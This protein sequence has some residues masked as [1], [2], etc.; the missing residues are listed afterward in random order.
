MPPAAMKIVSRSSKKKML[1]QLCKGW[2]SVPHRGMLREQGGGEEAGVC[3]PE[4]E[5]AVVG[6][7]GEVDLD[8]VSG[9]SST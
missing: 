6:I 9:T 8:A 7:V 3:V 5:E 4:G 1:R 2:A